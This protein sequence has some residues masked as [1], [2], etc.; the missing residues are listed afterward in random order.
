MGDDNRCGSAADSIC[1]DFTRMDY[2]LIQKTD[3]SNYR[4]YY[5]MC[6]IEHDNDEI[7]LFA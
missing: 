7:L 3:C 6:S 1:E 5:L 2:R 4:A